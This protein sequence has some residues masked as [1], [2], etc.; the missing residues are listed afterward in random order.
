MILKDAQRFVHMRVPLRA[1]IESHVQNREKIA[2]LNFFQAKKNFFDKKF[3]KLFSFFLFRFKTSCGYEVINSRQQIHEVLNR[4]RKKEK[5]FKMFFEKIFLTEK[6]KNGYFC[7]FCTFDSICARTEARAYAQIG[8]RLSESCC[9]H[10]LLL[11]AHS[12][13]LIGPLQMSTDD[14]LSIFLF[15]KSALL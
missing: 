2:I 11:N 3:W 14:F 5:T 10:F 6:V 7:I 9:I 4:K 1:Q 12:L 8:V 15:S 13:D